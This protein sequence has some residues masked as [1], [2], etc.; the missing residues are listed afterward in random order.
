MM[1][2]HEGSMSTVV[3]HEDIIVAQLSK[4][5]ALKLGYSQY[6][7]QLIYKAAVLH[8]IGKAAIP[9]EILLKPS[10]LTSDEYEIMKTHTTIGARMLCGLQN[11]L[12]EMAALVCEYHHERWDGN[13]YWKIPATQLPTFIFVVSLADVYV[14]CA[15]R[16]PY[17]EPWAQDE[18]L[19][20]I[21]DQAGGQFPPS[22]AQSFIRMMN[23]YD[24]DSID[25]S[26]SIDNVSNELDILKSKI[27]S[28]QKL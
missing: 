3:Q 8:D 18:I 16:R 11:P 4:I 19:E 22:I 10:K 26:N 23:G 6:Q 9:Q 12:K 14:A 27:E 2:Q 1:T 25:N 24:I 28:L 5:F 17:K 7:A 20:Y 21:K 15:M 13:G